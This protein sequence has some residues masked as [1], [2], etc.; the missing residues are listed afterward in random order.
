[1]NYL[2]YKTLPSLSCIANCT[3]PDRKQWRSLGESSFR[4]GAA[5]TPDDHRCIDHKEADEERAFLN[6]STI[7]DAKKTVFWRSRLLKNVFEND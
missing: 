7:V 5:S 4:L 3:T 6:L 1:V 2:A